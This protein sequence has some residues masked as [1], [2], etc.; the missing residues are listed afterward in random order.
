MLKEFRQA[1]FDEC[2]HSEFQIIENDSAVCT[3]ELT[4][5]IERMKTPEQESFS[6]LFLGPLTTF[7]PQGIRRLRHSSLGDLDIFLVPVGEKKDGFQYEAVFNK[8]L[9]PRE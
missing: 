8:L 9:K 6:L 5:I 3:L 2:V 1:I 4:E 7:V